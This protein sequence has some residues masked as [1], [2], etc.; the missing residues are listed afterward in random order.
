MA[1][2]VG[3]FLV[4]GT[5][6]AQTIVLDPGHGGHDNGGIPGQ[7]I[8]EKVIALDV[9][10]RA[11]KLLIQQGYNVVMTRTTDVFIPLPNRAYIANAHPDALLIS[12]HLDSARNCSARGV[13]AFYYGRKSRALALTLLNEMLCKM[14]HT[15][16]RDFRNRDLAVLRRSKNPA[17]LVELGFLTNPDEGK[18][19]LSPDF[20][21]KAAETLVAGIIKYN[22]RYEASSPKTR[23]GITSLAMNNSKKADTE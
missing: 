12:V 18:R 9:S 17:A 13:S 23:R 3:F 1:V 14:P 8:K 2:F 19:F 21:Q 4:T 15:H 6:A 16:N 22:E 11:R 7:R 20:R 10:L 5:F